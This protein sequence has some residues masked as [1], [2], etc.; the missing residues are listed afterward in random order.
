MWTFLLFILLLIIIMGSY[1]Q[2]ID[3][4]DDLQQRIQQIQSSSSSSHSIPIAQPLNQIEG[5]D[6]SPPV[7]SYEKE[8]ITPSSQKML[9][10][11]TISHDHVQAGCKAVGVCNY[12]YPKQ[13]SQLDRDL[14]LIKYPKDMTPQDYIHWLYAHN[15]PLELDYIDYQNYRNRNNGL[16]WENIQHIYQQT[17]TPFSSYHRMPSSKM[18]CAT[19]SDAVLLP[20]EVVS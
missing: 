1:Q 12:P 16:I 18:P 3:K 13:M 2:F 14:F 17:M 6:M 5:F 9:T 15:D 20:G 4:I 10:Y 8:L 11:C 7:Q 19:E